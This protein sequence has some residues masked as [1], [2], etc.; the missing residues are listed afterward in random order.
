MIAVG[1]GFYAYNNWIT[2]QTTVDG[3]DIP[4]DQ[5]FAGNLD[6]KISEGD[7]V[8]GGSHTSSNAKLYF[9]TVEPNTEADGVTISSTAKTI[10]IAR[11]SGGWGWISIHNEDAGYL[12]APWLESNFKNQNPRV[13]EVY[14]K[15]LDNDDKK[16]M[17]GKCWFGDMAVASGQDPE[18]TLNV[19]W[20]DEDVALADDDPA[21]QTGLGE[22]SGTAFAITWK[23]SG[24]T[25]GDGNVIGKVYVVT[26]DT[27]EGEDIRCEDLRMYGDITVVGKDSW[28]TPAY[29]SSSAYEAYYFMPTEYTDPYNGIL[30]YRSPQSADALYITLQGKLY[31]ETNNNITVDLYVILISGTGSTT[32]VTDSVTMS[33]A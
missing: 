16:E 21:D 19:Q 6:V 9:Y 15:D 11:T 13:K 20:V 1:G 12:I 33:E 18:W 23:L 5:L 3:T 26:N 2:P 4:I 7:F 25:A 28:S 14:Y 17:I 31:L 30:T 8:E 27:R 29:T 24:Y 22:V 10:E 32:Q